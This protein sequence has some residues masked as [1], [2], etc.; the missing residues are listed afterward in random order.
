MLPEGI[1]AVG[2]TLIEVIRKRH[3]ASERLTGTSSAG[4]LALDLPDVMCDFEHLDGSPLGNE[5]DT[6]VVAEHDIITRDDEVTD[7]GTRE[8]LGSA[9]V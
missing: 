5:K 6:I 4:L 2:G 1:A 3:L 7:P 8:R 9:F